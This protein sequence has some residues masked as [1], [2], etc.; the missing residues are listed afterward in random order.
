MKYKVINTYK[1][2]INR[3]NLIFKPNVEIEVELNRF[4]Y[5]QVV[6]CKH[7]KV[8]KVEEVIVDAKVKVEEQEETFKCRVCGKEYE[9]K[10][11][12]T[13]HMKKHIGEV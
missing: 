7:L 13:R 1:Y 12:L 8:T 4:E 5:L 2:N 10:S 3:A 6:A 9:T 11:S